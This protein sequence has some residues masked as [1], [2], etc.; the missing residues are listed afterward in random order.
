MNHKLTLE[1][2]DAEGALL[3]MLGTAERRGYQTVSLQAGPGEN[4]GEFAVRLTVRSERDPGLLA[5]QL[6]NLHDVRR[7]EVLP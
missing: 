2:R 3:R 5:R 6:A 4:T 7:V 1:V